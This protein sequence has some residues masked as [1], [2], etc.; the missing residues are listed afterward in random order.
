[1]PGTARQGK[2]RGVAWRGEAGR[3]KA[4]FKGGAGIDRRPCF[5]SNPK[6]ER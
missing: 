4:R 2:V 5:L 1:L 6:K 3:G